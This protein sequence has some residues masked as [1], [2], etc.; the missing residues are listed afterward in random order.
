[1]ASKPYDELG[2]DQERTKR[3]RRQKAWDAL[4]Q[5]AGTKDPARVRAFADSVRKPKRP[6][7]KSKAGAA[8]GGAKS[9]AEDVLA[10]QAAL[11]AALDAR[12]PYPHPFLV[13]DA[14]RTE[15]AG[16]LGCAPEA[17]H[18]RKVAAKARKM[19][20]KEQRAT[21][22]QY[23]SERRTCK[24][25]RRS[26][27]ATFV[28]AIPSRKRARK[29][30]AFHNKQWAKLRKELKSSKDLVST[31]LG[32]E[33]GQAGRPSW[34]D[35]EEGI[36]GR[37]KLMWKKR[38][39]P[40]GGKKGRKGL[41]VI[42]GLKGDV[43]LD[44]LKEVNQDREGKPPVSRYLVEKCCPK[45]AKMASS[46]GDLCPLCIGGAHTVHVLDK[47]VA[48]IARDHPVPPPLEDGTTPPAPYSAEQ[49]AFAQI[50]WP[51]K[52]AL[53][54]ALRHVEEVD[55]HKADVAEHLRY[56]DECIGEVPR[57]GDFTD[58]GR[59]KSRGYVDIGR[60]WKIPYQLSH[61]WA[62]KNDED[63]PFSVRSFPAPA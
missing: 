32:A 57:S 44:I 27:L 53:R 7:G 63:H 12:N 34:E 25:L 42:Q 51:R 9:T 41:L 49:W 5:E 54:K 31:A 16:K 58:K 17:V 21:V 10:S 6:S 24:A 2:P 30:V 26:M 29:F 55:L 61:H 28:H 48:E 13:D 23:D 47:I 22:D 33:R 38:T 40:A 43:S 39:R 20:T 14:A 18:V 60:R 62:S 1:M 19:L 8:K 4:A 50:D 56:K 11:M 37:L 45:N 52:W 3:R 36:E 15:L 59:T 46:R 35:V